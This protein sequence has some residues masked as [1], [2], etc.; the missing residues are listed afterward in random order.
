MNLSM[1][2]LIKY[3]EGCL[4]SFFSKKGYKLKEIVNSPEL[5][6]VI[7]DYIEK[8]VKSFKSKWAK[9][10]RGRAYALF[11]NNIYILKT[12]LIK[13][14]ELPGLA[15]ED[16]DP[17]DNY[18]K[19]AQKFKEGGI[20]EE[21]YL[22]EKIDGCLLTVGVYQKG[23]I[24]CDLMF[25]IIKTAWYVETDKLLFVPASR[26]TLF[27]NDDMKKYFLN[28]FSGYSKKDIDQSW[29]QNKETFLTMVLN[30]YLKCVSSKI[31][32]ISLIFEAVCENRGFKTELTVSYNI[33]CLFYLGYCSETVFIPHYKTDQSIIQ[34][35]WYRVRSVEEVKNALKGLNVNLRYKDKIYPEGFVYLDHTRCDDT[36]FYCKLKP[37]VYY[38][39]HKLKSEYVNE[40]LG[41]DDFYNQAYPIVKELKFIL[42]NQLDVALK[43]YKIE[44][45]K[46]IQPLLN[47]SISGDP[48]KAL[49]AFRKDLNFSF[50]TDYFPV[51]IGEKEIFNFSRSIAITTDPESLKYFFKNKFKV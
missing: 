2:I 19:I 34:P 6:I 41:L 3:K 8:A 16:E 49:F 5:T 25:K 21:S 14:F 47:H 7:I 29:K 48:I 33:N 45:D 42:S 15:F 18:L 28:S 39:C 1:L 17:D 31:G 27:L 36:P 51:N 43:A 30:I 32:A 9:E 46:Y 13:G 12:N 38:K 50:F 35:D 10:A 37:F 40:L 26:S 22:S 20:L 4:K 44:V 23:T 11:N 24:E